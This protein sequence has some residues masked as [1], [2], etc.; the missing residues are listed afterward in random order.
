MDILQRI[1]DYLY[2]FNPADKKSVIVLAVLMCLLTRYCIRAIYTTSIEEIFMNTKEKLVTDV[3][4]FLAM[5][6]VFISTNIV[7]TTDSFWILIEFVVCVMWYILYLIYCR[8]ERK[9]N[10]ILKKQNKSLYKLQIYYKDKQTMAILMIVLFF[11]PAM[12]I[13]YKSVYKTL[14]L[15]ACLV[16]VS[17]IEIFI[18]GILLPELFVK[19]AKNYF[20]NGEDKMFIYKRLKNASVICG[21]DECLNKASKYIVISI[22]ELKTKEIYHL[23][24]EIITKDEKRDLCKK[25]KKMRKEKKQNE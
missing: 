11:M 7:L 19:K 14:P 8:K 4:K 16:I 21:D 17:A 10:M 22:D 12:V 18:I 23:Q 1:I 13:V 3:F 15:F 5:L 2:D 9:T 25:L 20:K 24:S 6:V